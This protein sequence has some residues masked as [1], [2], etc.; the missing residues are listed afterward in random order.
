M[1]DPEAILRTEPERV[2]A[3]RVYRDGSWKI[4]DDAGWAPLTDHHP[5]SPPGTAL[6]RLYAWA[7]LCVMSGDYTGVDRRRNRPAA[8]Y[9]EVDVESLRAEEGADR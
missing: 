4:R 7:Y 6:K 2:E 8:Y 5:H 9:A 1:T 3:V